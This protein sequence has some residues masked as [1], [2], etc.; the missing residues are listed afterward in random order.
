MTTLAAG[1]SA[2]KW[3]CHCDY[4][5]H[6]KNQE[7]RIKNREPRSGNRT[8]HRAPIHRGKPGK[9]LRVTDLQQQQKYK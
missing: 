4:D 3:V 7:S 5:W 6:P 2:P 9:C 8:G 1:G